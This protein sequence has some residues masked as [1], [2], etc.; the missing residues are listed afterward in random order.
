MKLRRRSVLGVAVVA[1]VYLVYLLGCAILGT[2]PGVS[3]TKVLP[4]FV[5]LT[6]YEIQAVMNWTAF[7]CLAAWGTWAWKYSR[8]E[9]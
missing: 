4:F 2:R 8:N 9:E 1:T 7:L 5:H 6:G 3:G